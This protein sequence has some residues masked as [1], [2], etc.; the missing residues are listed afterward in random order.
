MSLKIQAANCGGFAVFDYGS[1]E[2]LAVYSDFAS[3]A[4]FFDAK[5]AQPST[6]DKADAI[7]GMFYSMDTIPKINAIKAYRKLTGEGLK[8][9]K[10]AIEA[11]MLRAFGYNR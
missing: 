3:V 6:A 5:T 11:A 7:V 4:Q 9:S 8:E 1:D 10:E 2:L